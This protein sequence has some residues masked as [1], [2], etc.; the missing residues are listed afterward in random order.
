VHAQGH[1]IS[2]QAEQSLSDVRAS[3]DGARRRATRSGG[4]RLTRMP[5]ATAQ[6][7]IAVGS[8]GKTATMVRA[9]L[10]RFV[11]AFDVAD[12]AVELVGYLFDF[13][14]EGAEVLGD[15]VDAQS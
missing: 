9:L 15:G 14:G 3:A 2:G 7:G 10:R 12:E 5:R 13:D 4:L 1:F 6:M 11:L 8:E